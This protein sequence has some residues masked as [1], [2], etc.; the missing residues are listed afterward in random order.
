M[1]GFT[2]LTGHKNKRGGGWLTRSN[3]NNSEELEKTYIAFYSLYRF[4]HNQQNDY[5]KKKRGSK[6]RI[7]CSED[8]AAHRLPHTHFDFEFQAVTDH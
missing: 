6:S 2:K 7:S 4:V 8:S 5:V 3:K 1:A